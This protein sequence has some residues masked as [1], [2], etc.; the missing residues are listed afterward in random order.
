MDT[1]NLIKVSAF[2]VSVAFSL[3][4]IGLGVTMVIRNS[5]TAVWVPVLT[6]V[7]NLWI[8]SPIS[9]IKKPVGRDLSAST[10]TEAPR[11]PGHYAS[12]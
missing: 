1:H 2:F 3:I 8:P 10:I 11:S 7:I 9:L 5:D 12:L 4:L 6:A